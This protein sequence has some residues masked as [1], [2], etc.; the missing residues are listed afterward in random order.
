MHADECRARITILWLEIGVMDSFRSELD[1]RH[2]SVLR[3]VKVEHL[4]LMVG[5]DVD[6]S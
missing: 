2:C 4:K 3:T 5:D 6:L 1:V